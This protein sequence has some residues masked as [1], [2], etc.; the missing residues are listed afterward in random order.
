MV[1]FFRSRF[2]PSP[3]KNIATVLAITITLGSLLGAYCGYNFGN[4][5]QV[6][7]PI[8]IRERGSFISLILVMSL[9]L[10][11]SLLAIYVRLNWLTVPI[12]LIKAFAVSYL[13]SCIQRFYNDSGWLISFLFLYSDFLTLPIL[14]WFWLCSGNDTS[15]KLQRCFGIAFISLFGIALFDYRFVSS[16]LIYLLS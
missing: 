14:C 12:V 5:T 16:Y 13:G 15:V 7:L 11:A 4:R 2:L 10:F 6:L 8:A 3:S 1:C 9:P